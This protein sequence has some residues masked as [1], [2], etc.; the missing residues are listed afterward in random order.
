MPPALDGATGQLAFLVGTYQEFR[1]FLPLWARSIP[2]ASPCCCATSNR[3]RR[4]RSV[5]S[6]S[7]R[8]ARPATFAWSTS[9]H[10]GRRLGTLRVA[11]GACSWPAPTPPHSQPHPE[12]SLHHHGARARMGHGA[13]AARHLAVRLGAGANRHGIGAGA[14]LVIGVRAE[15]AH[16]GDLGRRHAGAACRARRHAVCGDRAARCS[17]G[18]RLPRRRRSP[19]CWEGGSPATALGAGRDQPALERAP[20]SR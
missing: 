14:H 19:I 1:Q 7:S 11:S 18:T 16:G 13:A 4:G 9:A 6:A 10:D 3:T 12:R 5:S 20:P 17:T 15:P 2:V 8:V